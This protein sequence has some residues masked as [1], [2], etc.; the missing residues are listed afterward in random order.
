MSFA[1][2]RST[3]L[4]ELEQESGAGP[5]EFV[6]GDHVGV[7][8]GN[9]AELV[10][11]ILKLLT[12]APPTNQSLHLETL[13]TSSGSGWL[14]LFRAEQVTVTKPQGKKHLKLHH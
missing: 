7:F 4:V 2:S 3:I 1:F 13:A 12:D 10:T 8:P 5:L 11:G 9:P 14:L 6:P